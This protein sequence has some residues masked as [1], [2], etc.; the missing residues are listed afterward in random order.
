MDPKL[1]R[2]AQEISTKLGQFVIDIGEDLKIKKII[3]KYNFNAKDE[4]KTINNKNAPT[5]AEVDSYQ[6]LS[7]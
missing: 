6:K 3:D 2:G 5:M 4:D 7:F 1:K